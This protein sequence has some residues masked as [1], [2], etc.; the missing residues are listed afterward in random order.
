MKVNAIAPWFG[1]KRSIAAEIVRELGPHHAYWEPFCGSMAV[2]FGKEPATME[3]VNDLHGE[4]INL[5]RVLQHKGAAQVLYDRLHRTLC[6]ETLYREAAQRCRDR[7]HQPAS[8]TPDINRAEDFMTCTWLGMNGVAGT[9]RNKMGFCRRFTKNG[10]HAATRWVGAVDSIPDWHE[11]LRS[12][13]ILNADGFD[14]LERIEDAP[15]VAIYCDPPYIVKSDDY[16]HDFAAD[17]HGR[18]AKL[19]NRFQRARVLVS[20][21]EHHTVRDLYRGWNIVAIKANKA[22]ANPA[23]PGARRDAPEVLCIN[24]PVLTASNG[25][26]F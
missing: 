26:L 25:G 7:G 6:A 19:L 2:L 13:V 20:Y 9:K 22:L 10:G 17:D 21:Y 5:A 15:G 1:A 8:E 4:L 3:T 16:V 11:R 18:L 24:G 23:I 14:I 12:V